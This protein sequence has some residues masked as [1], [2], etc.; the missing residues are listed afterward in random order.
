MFGLRKTLSTIILA[1]AFVVLASL[2]SYLYNS[3]Q[4]KQIKTDNSSLVEKGK[5]IANVVLDTSGE[6]ADS[7][8]D[9]NTGFNNFSN[10]LVEMAR[11]FILTTDWQ[12]IISGQKTVKDGLTEGATSSATSSAIAGSAINNVKDIATEITSS[13]A[14]VLDLNNEA[15]GF[16]SKL[17]TGLK[18]EWQKIRDE[19]SYS[20]P[21]A[22]EIFNTKNNL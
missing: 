14:P 7:N 15:P 20:N 10:K 22:E 2:A 9:K 5:D 4:A 11:N 18:E 21:E 12:G 1:V 17:I 19:E 6:M 13:A 3:D 16:F 8:V